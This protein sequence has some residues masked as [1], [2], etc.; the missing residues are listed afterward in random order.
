MIS[1][2]T[3]RATGALPWRMPDVGMSFAMIACPYDC[4]WCDLSACRS[5]GCAK[6]GEVPLLVCVACGDLIIRS[7]AFGVC[8]E[9]LPADVHVTEVR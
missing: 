6:T 7:T 8:V 9:C 2:G 4:H 5:E 3:A 1:D